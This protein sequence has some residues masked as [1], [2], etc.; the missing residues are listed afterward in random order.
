MSWDNTSAFLLVCCYTLSTMATTIR[1]RALAGHLVANSG[2]SIY[3]AMVAVGYSP[4][5]ART[6][7]KAMK[8]KGFQDLLKEAGVTEDKITQTINEGLN[9]TKLFGKNAV[10]HP[11]YA[12]RHKFMESSLRLLGIVNLE[13]PPAG[14]TYNTF[15]NQTSLDPTSPKA[16]QLVTDTLEVL[17]AKTKRK[18]IDVE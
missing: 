2:T 7:A 14:D 13:P 17:M 18:V 12:V 10:K 11:D 5:T 4:N 3:K 15:I 8:S 6:P 9:A 16:K 1:Q